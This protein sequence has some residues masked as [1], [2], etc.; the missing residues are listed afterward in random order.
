MFN[1]PVFPT[2]LSFATLN[3]PVGACTVL[4]T[5]NHVPQ[6]GA[7]AR[8][9]IL[10][11]D[12]LP[13]MADLNRVHFLHVWPGPREHTPVEP[14]F[15]PPNSPSGESCLAMSFPDIPSSKILK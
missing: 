11:W 10:D 7:L 14:I 4:T 6:V 15:M 3:V 1:E 13:C 9:I 8:R 2:L 12:L 5:Q